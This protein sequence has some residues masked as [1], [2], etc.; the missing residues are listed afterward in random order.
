M[1]AEQARRSRMAA[2]YRSRIN[3]AVDYIERNLGRDF[4][5]EE[6]AAV[7]GFSKYHF[8]RIFHT[9]TGETLFQ[10][11]QRLRLEKEPPCSLTIPPSP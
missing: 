2:L 7:A 8:H 3:L 6:I 1:K 4:A 10:F 9:F 11:I 5:L